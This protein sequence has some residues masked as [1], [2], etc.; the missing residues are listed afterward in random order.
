MKA[1]SKSVQIAK[2]FLTTATN[3]GYRVTVE[4]GVV[5]VSKSF[6]KNSLDAFNE[7]DA[8]AAKALY[9]LEARGTQWGTDGIGG[10]VAIQNGTLTLTQG[11]VSKRVYEALTRLV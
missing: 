4:C 7:A 6:T 2:D 8:G 9:I 3:S 11:G 1:P 10:A 5:R